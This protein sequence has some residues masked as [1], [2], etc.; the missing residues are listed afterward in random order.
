CLDNILQVSAI[1]SIWRPL[2]L[3]L[4]YPNCHSVVELPP[5]GVDA[6]PQNVSLHAIIEKET[7][8]LIQG[9]PPK[10]P[11]CPAHHRQ[12]LNICVQDRQLICGICL[13]VGQ[14]QGHPIDNLQAAFIRERQAPA[15]L[16][17]RLSDHRRAEVCELGEQDKA[18][19]EGLVRQA[20]EQYFQGLELVLARKKDFHG[21]LGHRKRGGVSAPYG[22]MPSSC[23]IRRCRTLRI[24][25]PVHPGGWAHDLL[26][27]LQLAVWVNPVGGASLGFSLLSKLSKLVHGLSSE[28]T[29]LF[30]S[31]HSHW[32]RT[33]PLNCLTWVKCF[34]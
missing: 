17:A 18:S 33:L 26:L 22:Q 23:H 19:C 30:L 32:V 14:H 5:T 10:A 7:I 31:S 28:L 20:V 24:W 2:R 3:P 34:G 21:G 12:P 25:G 13:T 11:S 29:L 6:L 15:H 8:C 4:K 9:Q 16:L 27:Q 1:Y